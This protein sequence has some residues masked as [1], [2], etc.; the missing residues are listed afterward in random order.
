VDVRLT[1]VRDEVD[2]GRASSRS[3]GLLFGAA[4]DADRADDLGTLEQTL[5]LAHAIA[6]HAE[7]ALRG[8]AERLAAICEEGI[9]RV[10]AHVWGELAAP[11]GPSLGSDDSRPVWWDE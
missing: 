5:V 9:D 3:W 7:K 10:R 1:L 8:E 6:R 11:R 2:L 4:S